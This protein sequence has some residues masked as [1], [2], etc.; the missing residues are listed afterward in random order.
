MKDLYLRLLR[1]VW[2]VFLFALGIAITL[3]AQIGYAPW[4]VFHAG[5]AQSSGISIGTASI[6]IG[7]I[8]VILVILLKEKLGV[9][10]LANM[11][12]V[13]LL[14]DVILGSQILPVANNLLL[15]IAMLILG[16]FVIAL[17]SYFYI[18]SAFGAGPRDS[19]MV[20]LARKTGLAIGVCRGAIE[21]TALL[22]GWLLGGMVGLGTV[23]SVFM[24]GFSVQVTFKL[25]KFDVTQVQ[26]Q[27]LAETY[28]AFLRS[29][30]TD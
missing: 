10:T 14:L 16:L 3:N 23:I 2:G 19:L 15:G 17:A 26:H 18:G 8:I 29:S 22:G 1:L 24:A 5:V 7:V 4:D 30:A 21:L 25:L 28:R 11:I 6:G 12:V 9:G 27:T 13:G 20:A